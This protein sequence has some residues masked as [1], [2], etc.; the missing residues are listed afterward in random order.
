MSR[1][2]PSSA[3]DALLVTLEKQIQEIR[4]LGR[5]APPWKSE[6]LLALTKARD[7]LIRQLNWNLRE[8][9]ARRDVLEERYAGHPKRAPQRAL[10]AVE[11]EEFRARMRRK[12]GCLFPIMPQPVDEKEELEKM[13]ERWDRAEHELRRMEPY[14]RMSVQELKELQEYRNSIKQKKTTAKAEGPKR[15]RDDPADEFRPGGEWDI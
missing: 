6:L 12:T 10:T 13:L 8:V 15:P 1:N 2:F 5:K 14:A 9:Q 7:A 4:G 3:P 11:R